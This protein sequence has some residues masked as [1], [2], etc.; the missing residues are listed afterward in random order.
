MKNGTTDINTVRVLYERQTHRNNEMK[1]KYI[2]EEMQKY[3]QT[4]SKREHNT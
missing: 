4:E 3:R 1:I 2:K